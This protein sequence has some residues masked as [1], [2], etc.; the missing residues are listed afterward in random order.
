MKYIKLQGTFEQFNYMFSTDN[1]EKLWDQINLDLYNKKDI[2]NITLPLSIISISTIQTSI[3][4]I[5]GLRNIYSKDKQWILFNFDIQN[6]EPFLDIK[7]LPIK[8]IDMLEYTWSFMLKK[9]DNENTFQGFTPPE[10]D[11]LQTVIDYMRTGSDLPT[12]YVRQQRKLFYKNIIEYDQ[13]NNKN[14]RA[15]FPDM[16]EFY[17]QCEKL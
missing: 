17:E 3:N 7:L 11:N 14:F 5:N 12:D 13:L 4:L 2:L 8:Y 1:F 15:I 10:L 9:I 16:I 6:I